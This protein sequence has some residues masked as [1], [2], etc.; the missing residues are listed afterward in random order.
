L[1]S[2][3][4]LFLALPGLRRRILVSPERRYKEDIAMAHALDTPGTLAHVGGRSLAEAER[5]AHQ[6]FTLLR[7][8][9]TVLPIVAGLDKFAHLLVDWTQYLAPI[10]TQVTNLDP[11]TFMA[12]VGVV[13]IAAGLLVAWKPRIGGLVVAAWLWGIIVNLLMVPGYYDIAARDFGL[14]LGALALARLARHEY[15]LYRRPLPA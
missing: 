1:L 7:F 11:E 8:G 13:E 6:A 15:E 4:G 3:S 9:F 2:L 12:L 10:A 14:S 5:P